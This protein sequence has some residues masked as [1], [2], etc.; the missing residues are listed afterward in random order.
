[1]T[2]KKIE[3]VDQDLMGR[4]VACLKRIAE[5]VVNREGGDI[6]NFQRPTKEH[7]EGR[8]PIDDFDLRIRAANNLQGAAIGKS[9][10]VR[11]A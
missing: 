2:I 10:E 11:C 3:C 8:Q 7:N 4:Y 9:R 5:V 6:W 1:M